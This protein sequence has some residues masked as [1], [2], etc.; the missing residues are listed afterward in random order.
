MCIVFATYTF[1]RSQ[2][3]L[4]VYETWD[5]WK[6]ILT[7]GTL[8]IGP[9]YIVLSNFIATTMT[10]FTCLSHL[11]GFHLKVA[12]V[13]HVRRTHWILSPENSVRAYMQHLEGVSYTYNVT[14][15]LKKSFVRNVFH[16]IEMFSDLHAT[17]Q[18]VY[19]RTIPIYEVC[20]LQKLNGKKPRG[21]ISKFHE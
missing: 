2:P 8:H 12:W 16:C 5:T 6:P 21:P 15:P 20:R 3:Y 4:L 7:R 10:T 1:V 18:G 9:S 17:R 19:M 14:Y 13:C 11:C